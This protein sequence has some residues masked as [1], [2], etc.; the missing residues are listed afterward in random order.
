[1][2]NLT[3]KYKV[4]E[5]SASDVSS[6]YSF[7]SRIRDLDMK[8]NKDSDDVVVIDASEGPDMKKE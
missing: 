6:I 8:D 1:M 5:D 7:R 4:V 3:A 2:K